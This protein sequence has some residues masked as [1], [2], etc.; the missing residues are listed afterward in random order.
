MQEPRLRSLI[1]ASPNQVG[2]AGMTLLAWLAAADGGLDAGERHHLRELARANQNEEFFGRV[3]PLAEVGSIE[4]L[5]LACEI[6]RTFLKPTQRRLFLELAIG[7]ALGDGL[8]SAAE[9]HVLRFF[10]DLVGVPM[11]EFDELFRAHAGK[12]FPS[13]GDPSSMNWWRTRPGQR[14]SSPSAGARSR[15]GPRAVLGV[16]DDATMEE[17]KRAFYRLAMVHHPDRFHELGPVAV[18]EAERQFKQLAAAYEDLVNG[19]S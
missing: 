19:G 5:Q 7:V 6:L 17:I 13:P 8:L 14:S 2:L 12:A 16:T 3:L 11:R 10:S 1:E 9:N 15:S 18:A 4:D